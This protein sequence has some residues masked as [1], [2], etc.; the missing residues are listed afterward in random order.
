MNFKIILNTVFNFI[1]LEIK[2][3]FEIKSKIKLHFRYLRFLK[4]YLSLGVF[5]LSS[6]LSYACDEGGGTKNS[7]GMTMITFKC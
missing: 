3:H 6:V 1:V 7:I 5:F 2:L 4:F